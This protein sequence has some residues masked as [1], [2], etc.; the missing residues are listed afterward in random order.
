MGPVCPW[1]VKFVQGSNLNKMLC[2]PFKLF[3]KHFLIV[4]GRP[5]GGSQHRGHA[6]GAG[7]AP[8][9][10]ASQVLWFLHKI[11]QKSFIWIISWL[12]PH[13]SLEMKP[14]YNSFLDSPKIFNEINHQPCTVSKPLREDAPWSVRCCLSGGRKK[15]NLF[16]QR[17]LF[18][19]T[20]RK[21]WC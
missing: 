9:L 6:G 5:S 19:R 21:S 7:S 20:E 4:P 13:L 1:R 15:K 11:E 18:Q 3:Q 17:V 12:F 8:I 14:P 10:G 16:C 2:N